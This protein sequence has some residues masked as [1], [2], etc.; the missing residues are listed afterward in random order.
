VSTDFKPKFIPWFEDDFRADRLVQR[1]TP[2]QRAYCRNLTLESYYN[3]LRPYL[4]VDDNVLWILADA[5]TIED[6]LAAKAAVLLKFEKV[7]RDDGQEVFLNKRVLEE[8]EKMTELLDQRKRAGAASARA[9]TM[10]VKANDTSVPQQYITEENKNITSQQHHITSG[11]STLVEQSFNAR[12]TPVGGAEPSTSIDQVVRNPD[13]VTPAHKEETDLAGKL[14][15]IFTT[16]TGK[17][18]SRVGLPKALELAAEYGEEC[19]VET[20][21]RRLNGWDTNGLK[22]PL[23]VFCKEFQGLRSEAERV[24]EEEKATKALWAATIAADNAKFARD[25]AEQERQWAEEEAQIKRQQEYYRETG[26]CF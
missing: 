10:R 24:A 3:P 18:L 8:W 25:K 17:T 7:V 23:T 22:H 11:R 9:R 19:V 14:G 12:S 5:P 13:K 2:V 15:S 1:M 6:W 20:W 16:A 4:P 26:I 21:Q